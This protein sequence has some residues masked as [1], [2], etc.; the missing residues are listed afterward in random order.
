MQAGIARGDAHRREIEANEPTKRGSHSSAPPPGASPTP[1]SGLCLASAYQQVQ[2]FP[3]RSSLCLHVKIGIGFS[4][5]I[6]PRRTAALSSATTTLIG[7][8]LNGREGS[9]SLCSV[10]SL[11]RRASLRFAPHTYR[12]HFFKQFHLTQQRHGSVTFDKLSIINAAQLALRCGCF[13]YAV[14]K[15]DFL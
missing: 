3:R 4:I 8:D 11:G 5:R 1:T 6:I 15:N 10:G 14:A 9:E 12:H 2:A 13:T 7:I